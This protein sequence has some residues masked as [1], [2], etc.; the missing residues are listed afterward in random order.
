MRAVPDRAGRGGGPGGGHH[1]RG[2]RLRDQ[3]VQPGGSAGPAA[4][5]AAPGPPDPYAHRGTAHG[6]RLDHGRGRSRGPPGRRAYRTDRDRVRAAPVPH[7]QPAACA[8]QGADPGPGVELRLRWPGPRGRA[9]HQLPA[10]EDRRRPRAAD[11]HRPRRRLRTEAGEL[12]PARAVRPHGRL[13][14]WAGVLSYRT[15]SGKL[16]IGLVVL[17]GLASVVISVVT[18]QSLNNSLMSSLRA[19]VQSATT[20]WTSCATSAYLQMTRGDGDQD[21]PSGPAGSGN[22]SGTG[23]A[24]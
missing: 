15:I 16:I 21:Q 12:V 17:F 5:P 2:R 19:Q 7:A 14:R 9:V 23:Q 8:V 1:R 22:C 10:Q 18:A 11:P 6:R 20:T 3:A 4:R 24:P 13:A